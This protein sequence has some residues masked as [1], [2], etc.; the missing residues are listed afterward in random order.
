MSNINN[1]SL[2]DDVIIK[3]KDIINY[4]QCPA[5]YM[6]VKKG[7]I[8][9]TFKEYAIKS[10]M[11]HFYA[12]LLDRMNDKLNKE[13]GIKM[14]NTIR[15]DFNKF[16]QNEVVTLSNCEQDILNY[17]AKL[18]DKF[19][20]G[21]LKIYGVNFPAKLIMKGRIITFN[22]DILLEDPYTHKLYAVDIDFKKRELTS[23]KMISTVKYYLTNEFC[24]TSETSPYVSIYN[25]HN[26][27][28]IPYKIE[29]FQLEH[30]ESTIYAIIENILNDNIYY[31]FGF[32][33]DTCPYKSECLK[34]VI[35]LS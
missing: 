23:W 31:R 18:Y 15:V 34:D 35:R 9:T 33:C 2:E 32:W 3:L 13:H 21:Q 10:L 28:L 11:K 22:I 25:V 16:D 7:I 5:K 17:G 29:N 30:I 24:R 26:D 6:W 19:V 12:A 4:M 27:D 14:L 8:K 20:L 1:L